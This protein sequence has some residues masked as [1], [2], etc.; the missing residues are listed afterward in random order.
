MQRSR[1]KIHERYQG[2][3]AGWSGF[4]ITVPHR[5]YFRATFLDGKAAPVCSG[6]GVHLWRLRSR[7][8][9]VDVKGGDAGHVG[10]PGAGTLTLQVFQ[11]LPARVVVT[12][13]RADGDH[14][15][16]RRDACEEGRNGGSLAAVMADLEQ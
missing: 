13:E 3:G 10:A 1:K 12:V 9:A 11:R 4:P 2:K 16:M 5:T 15:E 8:G 7:T 6:F 14:G